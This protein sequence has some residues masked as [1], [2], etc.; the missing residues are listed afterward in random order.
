AVAVTLIPGTDAV[1]DRLPQ[2]SGASHTQVGT[3][4]ICLAGGA[5]F[6]RIAGSGNRNALTAASANNCGPR[7]APHNRKRVIA[8]PGGRPHLPTY[9]R[10]G[11]TAG[12]PN[13]SANDKS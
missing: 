7:A 2:D 5:G 3:N 10:S 8:A 12:P 13:S 9:R 11:G 6:T 1:A 4:T